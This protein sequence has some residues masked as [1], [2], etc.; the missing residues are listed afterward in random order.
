MFLDSEYFVGWRGSPA[1]LT[2]VPSRFGIHLRGIIDDLIRDDAFVYAWDDGGRVDPSISWLSMDKY[3]LGQWIT[4]QLDLR[5]EQILATLG[6]LIHAAN[7]RNE[8]PKFDAVIVG[9]IDWS[10]HGWKSDSPPSV[11]CLCERAIREID[12]KQIEQL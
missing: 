10:F 4:A 12:E 6:N 7:E 9:L 8:C 3:R 5:I 11:A 2:Y 1:Q